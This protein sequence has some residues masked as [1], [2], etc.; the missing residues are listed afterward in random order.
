MF[1]HPR[2]ISHPSC[3]LLRAI[4]LNIVG[5]LAPLPF[6][7]WQQGLPG[8]FCPRKKNNYQPSLIPNYYEQAYLRRKI[9]VAVRGKDSGFEQL[10]EANEESYAPATAEGTRRGALRS[11]LRWG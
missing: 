4:L 3:V 11:L 1:P 6:H 9:M 8:I 2:S 10:Q 7:F 5:H